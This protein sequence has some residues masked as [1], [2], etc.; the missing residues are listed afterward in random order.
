MQKTF[1]QAFQEHLE[2]TGAKVTDIALK[3][4][5][6]KEA[7]YSLKYGKSR[8]MAVDDAIRVAAAFDQTVEEFMG[9]KEE[10]VRSVLYEQLAQLTDR[11]RQIVIGTAKAI[12][13][14]RQATTP[15]RD[16]DGDPEEE[17][18]GV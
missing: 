13:A 11:E 6:S 3:S 12:L 10:D 7:L 4:G 16:Q 15:A 2:T 9:L 17:P 18:L 5:V 14:Q 1:S 8:N